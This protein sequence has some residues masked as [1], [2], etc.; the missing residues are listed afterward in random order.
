[1]D[2]LKERQ[3]EN[4]SWYRRATGAG[5][6]LVLALWGFQFSGSASVLNADM[7]IEEV[8]QGDLDVLVAGYGRL[9]SSKQRLISALTRAT[10]REIVLQ[11]GASVTADSIIL[12][13]ENFELR[14]EVENA[15]QKLAQ[16][17]AN[18]RQ[19]R[20]TQRR[21]MLDETAKLAEVST[22]YQ[23]SI[24]H[25]EAYE[26]F[27]RLGAVAGIKYQEVMLDAQQWAQQQRVLNQKM[28]QLALVHEEAN[29]VERERI[30]QQ[31]GQVDIARS[32]VERLVVRAGMEGVLQRLSVE[33]G[34]SLDMGQKIALIGSVTDLV[35]LIRVPQIHAQAVMVGQRVLINTRR[36]EIMGEVSRIDPMVEENTVNIEVSLLHELPRSA[37]PQL[38][39]DATIVTDTLKQ[40]N[41][42]R[43][44]VYIQENSEGRLYQLD[45]DRKGAEKKVVK[46]GRRAGEYIEILSATKAGDQFIISDLSEL[47]NTHSRIEIDL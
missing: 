2:V 5:A 4:R 1:M 27:H 46:F 11:P 31:Q 15:R 30:K 33:L 28:E 37:R 47:L 38:N 45:S 10:V 18:Q 36:D 7:L 21:E 34:Q 42:I 13:L 3:S 17:K 32:R 43:R 12:R 25:R 8:Q 41:Y 24:L 16:L 26:K 29:T 14:Q 35:A 39:V 23:K 20:L 9:R 22:S 19:L 44:P 40:V 6:L